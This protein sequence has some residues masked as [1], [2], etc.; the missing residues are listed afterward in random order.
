MSITFVR[1]PSQNEHRRLTWRPAPLASPGHH[2]RTERCG[3]RLG[4][5]VR[6]TRATTP[7]T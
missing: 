3:L 1:Q 6:A 2:L 4:A 5:A 7:D